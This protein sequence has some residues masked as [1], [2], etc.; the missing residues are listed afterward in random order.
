MVEYILSVIIPVYNISKYLNVCIDSVIQSAAG[1]SEI[2]LVDDGSTDGS[3][4]ICD[5]YALKYFNISVIHKKN[6]GLVSARKAG[7]RDASGKYLTFVDGDDFVDPDLYTKAIEIL[8]QEGAEHNRILIGSFKEYNDG[9]KS[10]CENILPS[11]VYD[12]EKIAHAIIPG[13]LTDSSFHTKVIPAV[14]I[15]YF[16]T[17]LFIQCMDQVDDV[18]RDGEDVLFSIACL[19]HADS[20]RIENSL[21]GYNYRIVDES[22]SHEYNSMYYTNANAMCKCLEQIISENEIDLSCDSINY[23]ESYMLFRYLRKEYFE[24]N[25]KT[26]FQRIN[27]LHEVI[28]KTIPGMKIKKINVLSMKIPFPLKVELWLLQHKFIGTAY[29]YAYIMRGIII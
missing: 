27:T 3:S 25:G 8:Q 22:M 11:G 29:L 16:P 13:I 1:Q 15:K 18:V 23:E 7:A 19:A 28:G 21:C 17:E 12:R 10:V 20:V 5:D 6:G 14:W 4:D 26:F 9:K 24:K 2:I